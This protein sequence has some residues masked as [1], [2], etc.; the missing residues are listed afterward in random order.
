MPEAADQD[1]DPDW[2]AHEQI[3]SSPEVPEIDGAPCDVPVPVPAVAATAI[4]LAVFAPLNA[5]T[6]MTADDPDA[7]PKE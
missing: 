6:K 7:N 4:G 5:R 1:S 3:S 2:A